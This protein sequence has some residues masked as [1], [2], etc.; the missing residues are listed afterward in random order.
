MAIASGKTYQIVTV[1]SHPARRLFEILRT[2]NSLQFILIVLGAIAV[3]FILS[4]SITRPLKSLGNFSRS[5]AQGLSEHGL[6]P[7]LLKRADE[8]GDLARD[9]QFMAREVSTTL[10]RQKQLLYDVSHELRAPL[11]RLQAA[12]ALVAQKSE[13]S[14]P[15]TRRVE[16]ECERI[17]ALIQEILDFSRMEQG[18]G[19]K[20]TV[21]IEQLIREHV[22]NLRFEYPERSIRM[23]FYAQINQVHGHRELIGR[24]VENILR[25]ACKY[26]ESSVYIDLKI[27]NRSSNLAIVIR[28]HGKGVAAQDLEKLATPFYRA[29]NEMHTEGFGLGLSSMTFKNH[30][31]GGFEVTLI[32]PVLNNPS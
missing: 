11:A 24:A 12:A 27:E 5:Y 21:N 6:D 31:Q 1:P 10:E 3:S 25:N 28:D 23:E 16:S 18:L 2:L 15:Y 20:Q 4:W 30:P 13:E 14:T 26:T 22:D 9:F 32:L 19:E 29:G 7:G 8:I 17:N